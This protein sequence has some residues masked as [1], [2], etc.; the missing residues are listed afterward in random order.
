LSLTAVIASSPI[1]ESIER[2]DAAALKRELHRAL[3]KIQVLEEEIAR[4]SVE[5]RDPR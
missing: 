5:S 3:L 4:N 1:P 2:M